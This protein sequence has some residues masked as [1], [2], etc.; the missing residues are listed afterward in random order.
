M[1]S[2]T[3]PVMTNVTNLQRIVAA[4]VAEKAGYPFELW[5]RDHLEAGSSPETIA[6]TIND[7]IGVE[8][9]GVNGRT[10]RRW[11]AASE[12]AA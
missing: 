3:V 11:I 6:K 8:G 2:V 4:V 7:M 9:E 12:E 10:L 1:T 5:L